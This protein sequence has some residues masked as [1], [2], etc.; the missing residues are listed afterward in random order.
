M[1]RRTALLLP[2]VLAP[3]VVDRD[4]VPHDLGGYDDDGQ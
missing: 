2:L 1:D 3:H 4:V